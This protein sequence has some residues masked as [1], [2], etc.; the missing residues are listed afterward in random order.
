MPIAVVLLVVG[1]LWLRAPTF[2]FPVW[3]VDEAIHAAVA[4][5]LQEG[6]VLY[7]DAI[8]QRTPLT[9]V[10]MAAIFALTGSNNMLAVHLA[11]ALLI[12]STGVLLL[13][14]GRR[15]M[16]RG[17]GILAGGL[18]VLLSTGLFYQGD[19]N[20]F[21]TE[22]FVA[23]FTSAAALCF[24]ANASLEWMGRLPATGALLSLAVLSKQPAA[25]DLAAPALT[26]AYLA[27]RPNPAGASRLG[28]EWLQLGLGFLLP[29]LAVLC[30]YTLHG[31][32]PD[33][34]F[35]AWTYN[36]RYYGPE[37]GSA[38]RLQSAFF[39]F[40][41]MAVFSPLLLGVTLAAGADA[42]RRLV[43]RQALPEEHSTNPV[44][45][46]LLVW[47]GASLVGAASGGRGYDHY[48]IQC[49]PPLC[50]GTG[51][52]LSQLTA[53]C[54]QN[55]LRWYVRLALVMLLGALAVSLTLSV[56]RARVRTLPVDPSVRV[57][58][59][60]AEHSS[61]TD[62]IFVWGYHPDIYLYADRR[63]ASR[64]VYASFLTGLIPWTN[65][66]PD[67]DTTYAIVPGAMETLLREFESTRPVFV[68]DCSAGPNR[69]WDKYPLE[70]SPAL[71]AFLRDRYAVVESDQFIGQGFRLLA[72]R[73]SY[74]R[75]PLKPGVVMPANNTRAGTA[76]V[77]SPPLLDTKTPVVRVSA[78]DPA[79][80]LYRLE[81]IADGTP[82]DG[83]SFPSA[84]G[85]VAD[86]AVSFEG[87]PGVNR[88]QARATSADGAVFLSPVHEVDTR[89]GQIPSDQLGAFKLPESR[90]GLPPV[91]AIAPL[92]ASVS[93]EDGHTVYYA[94]APSRFCY[95]L[96]SGSKSVRGAH[97]FR[98]GAYSPDNAHPTDGAVFSVD[99]I[100]HDGHRTSLYRRLATPLQKPS[101][102]PVI[103]FHVDLPPDVTGQIEF[104]ISPGP[105]GNISSDWTFWSDLTIETSR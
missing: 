79:G 96:P 101:D 5:T 92:G 33:F 8:D 25:I 98:P 36:L 77:Y 52:T 73:D 66:A 58:H 39:P 23:F 22:W 34:A 80:L 35:Y 41:L 94:H 26:L 105:T 53:M 18:Y 19:A 49:L 62:R 7:R 78:A 99:W 15:A 1:T 10:A 85:I 83:V 16:D 37:I 17:T 104:V 100:D 72:I 82:I 103:Q 61:P 43:Q 60:I 56:L 44:R 55:R 54:L 74:R 63:P 3:N 21:V 13:L 81:L 90:R 57:G 68:V 24:W 88:L 48:A 64:F 95:T 4:R 65:T 27:R 42:Y 75:A 76:E 69:H 38:D 40:R 89:P 30:Y 93:L 51:W 6:G 28:R 86:F 102:R 87:H 97:G 9:Y 59:Y 11:T 91:A 2:A 20:A 12:A 31:A 67:R 29:L 50:L 70:K 14:T 84:P 45:F 32:L 47:G 71:S 46:Y